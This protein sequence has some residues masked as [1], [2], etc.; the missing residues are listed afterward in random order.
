MFISTIVSALKYWLKATLRPRRALAELKA[1]PDKVAIAL[2]VNV[3]FAILYSITAWIY[4][5]IGRLPAI[6]PWAPIPEEQYYLYQTFWT[7]PWGLATWIMFSGIAHLLA[8]AGKKEPA[9]YSFEDALVVGGLAW[10]VPNLILMWLPET[11]LVPIFG[12]FWPTW[13]E[14]LRLMALP[15]LWQSVFVAIG[16][17][18]THDVGWVWGLVIGLVTVTVFFVSFLAYMR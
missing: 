8:I 4:H 14:T 15:P 11:V 7:L 12:V 18:E 9:R 1:R 3:I 10:V 16:L 5:A 13:V 17:R 6:A 2:W